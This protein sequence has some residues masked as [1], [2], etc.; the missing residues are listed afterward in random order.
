MIVRLPRGTGLTSYLSGCFF[1]LQ[2]GDVILHAAPIRNVY[3]LCQARSFPA[4]EFPLR[5]L[6]LRRIR[7]FWRGCPAEKRHRVL[8]LP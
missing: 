7:A 2:L 6:I 1:V 3:E 4:T 8:V 5:A